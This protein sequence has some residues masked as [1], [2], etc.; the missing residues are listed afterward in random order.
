MKHMFGSK[1]MFTSSRCS[2]QWCS[3]MMHNDAAL[4]VNSQY[5]LHFEWMLLV[6][7]NQYLYWTLDSQAA[8]HVE[9]TTWVCEQSIFILN[10]EQ[11]SCTWVNNL[12]MWTVNIYIEH[13]TVKLHFTLNEQWTWSICEQSKFILNTEQ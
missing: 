6:C 2:T 13:W 5:T 12:S 10:T 4:R 9:W 3:I 11:S 1:S 7:D 8:L